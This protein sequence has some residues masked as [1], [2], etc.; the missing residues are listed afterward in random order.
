MSIGLRK[1]LFFDFFL[2]LS[3]KN[4]GVVRDEE[5]LENRHVFYAEKTAT[6]VSLA[7]FAV[8]NNLTLSV[9]VLPGNE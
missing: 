3:L 1:K 4:W 8:V 6:Y 7:R 2:K 9:D 5:R